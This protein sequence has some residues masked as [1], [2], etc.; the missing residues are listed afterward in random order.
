MMFILSYGYAMRLSLDDW[1]ASLNCMYPPVNTA[2]NTVCF[3][4][5]I[6][7]AREQLHAYLG[8][9][10]WIEDTNNYPCTWQV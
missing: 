2:L 6:I 8:V 4:S 7:R 10:A 1:Y 3:T 5:D 9:V